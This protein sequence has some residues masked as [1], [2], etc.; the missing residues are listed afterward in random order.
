M[1]EL[2]PCPFC[3]EEVKTHWRMYYYYDYPTKEYYAMCLYH[4]CPVKPKT[5]YYLTEEEAIKAWNT[6]KE[7]DNE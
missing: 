4:K 6:R 7:Q 5:M 2:K 3:G 1:S